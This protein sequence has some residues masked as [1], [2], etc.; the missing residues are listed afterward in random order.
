MKL[1]QERVEIRG[2]RQFAMA[3]AC[4]VV[5]TS[6]VG[7]GA[8]ATDG[9]SGSASGGVGAPERELGEDERSR[10]R[11]G[12]R[13]LEESCIPGEGEGQQGHA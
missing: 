1:T 13:L 10:P 7:F 11:D 9:C 6:N 3:M 8:G 2:A 12:S 4:V 5:W